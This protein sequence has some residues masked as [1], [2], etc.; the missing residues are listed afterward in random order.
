L[1]QMLKPA[2]PRSLFIDI[3][4]SSPQ[5][6][7]EEDDAL[8]EQA[9]ADWQGTPVYLATHFQARS[10]ADTELTVTRPLPR[11]AAHAELASVTLLPGPDGLVREMRSSWQLEGE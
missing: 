9:L 5:R 2:G 6:S 7:T 8:L 10:L 3:D 11:F 1:L 4:F